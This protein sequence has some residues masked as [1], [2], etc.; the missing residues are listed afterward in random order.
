MAAAA[1]AL[2][3]S[4]PGTLIM[5]IW[6]L[7]GRGLCELDCVAHCHREEGD[8]L[9]YKPV[10]AFAQRVIVDLQNTDLEL[11]SLRF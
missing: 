2:F 1:A 7:A 8:S 11:Q 3:M 4:A 10:L 5:V 9:L 6:V